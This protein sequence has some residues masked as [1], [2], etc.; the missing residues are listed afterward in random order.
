MSKII[1]SPAAFEQRFTEKLNSRPTNATTVFVDKFPQIRREHKLMFDSLCA[2]EAVK[3][4][5]FM[6]HGVES[7]EFEMQISL[8]QGAKQI[9]HRLGYPFE[10]IQYFLDRFV[11]EGRSKS[12]LSAKQFERYQALGVVEFENYEQYLISIS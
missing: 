5:C 10:F 11:K 8:L 9:T 6:E 7:K 4:N 3:F 2:F 12:E 1:T